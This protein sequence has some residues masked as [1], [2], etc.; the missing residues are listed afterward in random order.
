MA[1]HGHSL[2]LIDMA[3]GRSKVIGTEFWKVAWSPDGKWIAA[4]R[5]SNV[6]ARIVLFEAGTFTARKTLASSTVLKISWSPD[7]R[8]LLTRT[9]EVGCGPDEYTY[10]IFDAVTLKASIVESSGCKIL[11]ND[12]DVGWVDKAILSK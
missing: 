11:G 7:S 10:E 9:L 5:F 2:E 3:N 12:D 4:A 6:E 1:I 8:F